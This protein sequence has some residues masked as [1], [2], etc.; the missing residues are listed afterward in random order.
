MNNCNLC[1][2]PMDHNAKI[3]AYYA[4]GKSV[5]KNTCKDC[6]R[7]KWIN[8]KESQKDLFAVELTN[9]KKI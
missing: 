1:K 2:K 3:I 7:T 8:L 4:N 9:A 5:Y 6:E